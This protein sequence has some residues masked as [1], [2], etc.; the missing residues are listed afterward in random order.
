MRQSPPRQCPQ[1][2]PVTQSST[3][4]NNVV[5]PF[6]QRGCARRHGVAHGVVPKVERVGLVAKR[7]WLR[8]VSVDRERVERVV[9]EFKAR[10]DRS[11]PEE[12]VGDIDCCA[13]G[14]HV[15]QPDDAVFAAQSS[16]QHDFKTR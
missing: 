12:Q 4:K 3:L 2:A 6:R 5:V 9:G 16:E 8:H 1:A 7:E 11:G 14:G 10:L 13:V 15:R